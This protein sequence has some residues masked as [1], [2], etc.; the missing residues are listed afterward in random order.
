V[1]DILTQPCNA[2]SKQDQELLRIDNVELEFEA[3]A[4]RAIASEAY[5]R[6]SEASFYRSVFL[7]SR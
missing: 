5:Q 7:L 3:N 1:L 6:N 4:L 2:L